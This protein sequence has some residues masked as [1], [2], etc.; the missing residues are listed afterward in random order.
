MSNIISKIRT[1]GALG[2][3][4]ERI[5]DLLD[6]KKEDRTLLLI[7][8]QVPGNEYHDAYKNGF[9]V[10]EWNI[11]AELAKQAE[12]GDIDAINALANRSKERSQ[13]DLKKAL[14]GL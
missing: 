14:F 4:H 9:A 7:Q 6:L 13:R 12:K 10:G 5:A 8:L 1:Y 11:D 3:S 2:Y